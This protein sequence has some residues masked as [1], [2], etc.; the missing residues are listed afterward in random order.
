MRAPGAG[1]GLGQASCLL[2]RRRGAGFPGL[3][4]PLPP[5][6]NPPPHPTPPNP[7]PPHPTPPTQALRAA[8]KV[9]GADVNSKGY[10]DLRGVGVIQG[11]GINIVTLKVGAACGGGLDLRGGGGGGMRTLGFGRSWPL[12][13]PD[14]PL[15]RLSPPGHPGR[16]A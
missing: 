12:L 2:S 3:P 1:C 16:G 10:K 7:I 14:A 4:S 11:D 6:R 9:F 5:T 13:G 8:E 15:H